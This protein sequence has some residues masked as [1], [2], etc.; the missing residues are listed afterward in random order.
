MGEGDGLSVRHARSMLTPS[1]GVQRS[2]ECTSTLSNDSEPFTSS[3]LSKLWSSLD[4]HSQQA[5]QVI[6]VASPVRAR[7]RPEPRQRSHQRDT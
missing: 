4:G 1:L 5:R 2:N 6:S 7:R 3:A